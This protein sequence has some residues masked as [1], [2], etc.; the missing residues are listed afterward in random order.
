MSA[1]LADERWRDTRSADDRDTTPDADRGSL[2]SA[3]S[4]VDRLS[5][6]LAEATA[7]AEAADADR[8]AAE[9]RAEGALKAIAEAHAGEI[10]ALRE[11]LTEAQAQTYAAQ[12]AARKA[13]EA[14]V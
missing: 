5:T 6:A 1:D 2:R 8:R 10:T 4:A 3:L 13:Q 11:R 12:E 9:A 7:R 14:A